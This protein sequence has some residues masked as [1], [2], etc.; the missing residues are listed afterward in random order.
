MPN[1][2]EL[3]VLYDRKDRYKKKRNQEG[4]VFGSFLIPP[5]KNLCPIVYLLNG[6]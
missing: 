3:F 2:K 4:W 1:I 5:L 6:R